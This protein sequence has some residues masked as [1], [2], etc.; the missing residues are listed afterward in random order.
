MRRRGHG[1]IGIAGTLLVGFLRLGLQGFGAEAVRLIHNLGDVI[2]GKRRAGCVGQA[3]QVN[4]AGQAEN[5]VISGGRHVVL[6]NPASR[7]GA[8]ASRP[9]AQPGSARA[10]AVSSAAAARARPKSGANLKP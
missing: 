8:G 10:S 4:Q 1:A 7:P 3:G 6:S 9:A 2:G 5:Q